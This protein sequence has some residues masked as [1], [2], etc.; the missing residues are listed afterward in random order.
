MS[1]SL[2]HIRF[3]LVNTT[4]PGNIGAAAR[5]MA[6]MGFDQLTLVAP[7]YFPHQE[8]TAR[9]SGADDVLHQARV[10]DSLEAAIADCEIVV[11][12]SARQR[13]LNWPLLTPRQTAAKLQQLSGN[14]A[15][16]FGCEQFGLSNEQ[17]SLCHFHC[18]IPTNENFSSLN[19]AQAVQVLA[20]ELRINL[21]AQPEPDLITTELASAAEVN[22]FLS[23]LD[24]L[25]QE[26]EFIQAGKEKTLSLR[27]RRLFQRSMLETT[28]VNILRG[29]L[30]TVQKKL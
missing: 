2:S 8:A 23:H 18:C 12:T 28:E 6:N 24:E 1:N 10:V 3:V 13:S 7:K 22:G 26:I 15:V 20:Y 17:L 27:L 16:I 30:S 19:L 29:I 14:V 11:G 21:V 9:A 5:A 4:H 25:L